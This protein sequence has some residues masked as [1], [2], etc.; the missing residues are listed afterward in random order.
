[1]AQ[2]GQTQE[3]DLIANQ[4]T[5]L[6]STLGAQTAALAQRLSD[7]LRI[8]CL[9]LPALP[10]NAS[11]QEV[12]AQRAQ[13]M[14]CRRE[15]VALASVWSRDAIS[16]EAVDGASLIGALG[17]APTNSLWDSPSR[18]FGSL[19]SLRDP[20]AAFVLPNPNTWLAGTAFYL[21]LAENFP[22]FPRDIAAADLQ[23]LVADGDRLQNFY[24]NALTNNQHLDLSLLWRLLQNYQN[25]AVA[26]LHE[27]ATQPL[28][29]LGLGTSDHPLPEE[30][31]H[32]ALLEASANMGQSNASSCGTVAS[33]S[34]GT[35]G[36]SASFRS[37][38][39]SAINCHPEEIANR[40]DIHDGPGAHFALVDAA[41]G[42]CPGKNPNYTT[43]NPNNP[44][45]A[46]KM[47]SI[48]SNLAQAIHLDNSIL[49]FVPRVAL[50]L[51]KLG[52]GQTKSHAC[53]EKYDV[54]FSASDPS[55]RTFN[56]TYD[57][58]L[59]IYLD[60]VDAKGKPVGTF[61]VSQVSGH[62]TTTFP[63]CTRG[64]WP[65]GNLKAMWEGGNYCGTK[66]PGIRGGFRDVFNKL[67]NTLEISTN[68]VSLVRLCDATRLARVRD[69][70]E[71]TRIGTPGLRFN[72]LQ[73]S[74]Q[75]LQF[76]T[77]VGARPE[78]S[79]TLQML[80]EPVKFVTPE[81]LRGAIFDGVTTVAMESLITTK[82][83]T[84]RA[85]ASR[86]GQTAVASPVK[87]PMDDNLAALKLL[88]QVLQVTQ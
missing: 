25:A 85:Q 66:M 60:V 6:Q 52:G 81:R 15:A 16:L 14:T 82:I 69:L 19:Q 45:Y 8:E 68:I 79:R 22:Q 63:W 86:D 17:K 74:Y 71:K 26:F 62:Q 88:S 65:S 67:P 36:A 37:I 30:V 59:D 76:F 77:E 34:Y 48:I 7:K 75:I 70:D 41:L 87:T 18:W 20:G 72:E 39:S 9:S 4:V 11:A 2:K 10:A 5:G 56:G 24:R 32:A 28:A 35:F 54:D 42:M 49:P 43:Q 55:W 31:P 51:E 78:Y 58:V 1:M 61:L 12:R 80:H 27:M 84:I 46:K 3:L 29:D 53:F 21:S 57:F 13:V 23:V 47:A 50:W 64:D 83:G 40:G 38:Q 73:A 33:A 44:P